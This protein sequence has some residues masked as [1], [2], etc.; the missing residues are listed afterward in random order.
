MWF[1]VLGKVLEEMA[2][3]CII[4]SS[5]IPHVEVHNVT[6]RELCNK[7]SRPQEIDLKNKI[8]SSSISTYMMPSEWKRVKVTPIYKSGDRSDPNSY[9]PIS[10][11][12]LIPKIMEH[13]IQFQLVAFLTKN[14]SLAV[15]RSGFRKKHSTETVTVYFIDHILEQMDKQRITGSIFI[16]LKKP[17]NL[18]DHHCLQH[19]LEHYGITGNSLKLFEDYLTTRRQKV[20][21]NQDMSSSLTIW[22]PKD[23]YWARF[24][25]WYTS[26]I[27][28]KAC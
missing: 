28:R 24:S 17:F 26:T 8:I 27:S 10:V 5:R 21:Y 1:E 18:V 7:R 19:K 23:L 13:A 16:D 25:L 9:H 2:N 15:H 12:R 20:K 14:S 6:D 3:C 4:P 22:S 11:L